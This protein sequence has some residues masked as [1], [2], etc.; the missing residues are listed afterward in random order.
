MVSLR[1]QVEKD[2]AT[3]LE[4]EWSLPVILVGPDGK[5]YNTSIHNDERLGGQVLYDIVRLSPDTGNDIVV[6]TP[7]VTLRRT[8]LERVPKAGEKWLVKIP[9]EPKESAPL[10]DFIL[11]QDRPPEGGGSIGFI[12]LYL[13]RVVQKT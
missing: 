12:R 4:G 10:A 11:D 6:N 2:L 8:S 5:T 1:E 9:I 13:R 3:T 7:V